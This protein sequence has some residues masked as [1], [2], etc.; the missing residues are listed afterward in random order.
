MHNGWPQD[1]KKTKQRTLVLEVLNQAE[2]P[3]GAPAI[4]AELERRGTPV[5]IS[6]VYRVLDTFTTHGVAVKAAELEN[7]MAL[8]EQA[9]N[10]HRHYA[11]CLACGKAV[12][13][14]HCPLENRLGVLPDKGFRVVAHKLQIYGYCTGCV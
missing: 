11:V 2:I 14:A 10:K 8:Y 3:L 4:A 9:G 6:T 13:L 7:G 5:W 1:L 12:P